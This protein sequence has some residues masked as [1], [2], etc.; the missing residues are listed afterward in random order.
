MAHTDK[1]THRPTHKVSVVYF[2]G[3][4]LY[5]LTIVGGVRDALAVLAPR[6]LLPA[7]LLK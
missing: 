2:G 1:P 6:A 3:I 7:Q 5:P 4:Y